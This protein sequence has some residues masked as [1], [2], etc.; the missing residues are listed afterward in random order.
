MDS[1]KHVF[2]K[3]ASGS[4]SLRPLIHPGW[5]VKSLA[6]CS[7]CCRAA[8]A[9]PGELRIGLTSVEKSLPGGGCFHPG[10]ISLTD[11]SSCILGV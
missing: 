6:E 8:D 2:L 5:L 7:K 1:Q 10:E 3:L 4:A 9:S 11:N